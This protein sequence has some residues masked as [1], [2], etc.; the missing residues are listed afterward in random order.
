M[1]RTSSKNSRALIR[2]GLDRSKVLLRNNIVLLITL[3]LLLF[4]VPVI[5][6]KGTLLTS[7]LLGTLVVSGL[8]AADFIKIAFRI[9]ATFGA[10]VLVAIFLGHVFPDS[11]ELKIISFLLITLFFMVVT[12]ALAAHVSTAREVDGATLLAAINSYLLIGITLSILF[13]ILDL[14]VPASFSQLDSGEADFSVFVYYGLVTLSTL[15]YGDITPDTAMARSLST[16]TALLGQLY[17]VII[18]AIIIGKYLRRG[19]DA[20]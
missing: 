8:F 18:M 19:K 1:N 20:E 13:M 9:L 15:G 3:F 4:F 11:R 10:L 14:F 16:F 2:S 6:G 5:P 17:L 12:I 7:L